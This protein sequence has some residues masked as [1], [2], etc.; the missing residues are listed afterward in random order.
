MKYGAPYHYGDGDLAAIE[1]RGET[2]EPL[3]KLPAVE[4][5]NEGHG[6]GDERWVQDHH[7]QEDWE[8]ETQRYT[9]PLGKRHQLGRRNHECPQQDPED[10]VA[11]PRVRCEQR[12]YMADV[13]DRQ[14]HDDGQRNNQLEQG[15]GRGEGSLLVRAHRDLTLVCRRN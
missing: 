4:V 14:G 1:Q 13:A 9:L 12:C 7:G 3:L 8:A 11:S 10:S 5:A 6:R 2:T 15:R